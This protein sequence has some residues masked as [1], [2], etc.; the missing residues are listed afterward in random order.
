MTRRIAVPFSDHG[1]STDVRTMADSGRSATSSLSGR[2]EWATTS[3]T[4]PMDITAS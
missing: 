3:S 2:P 4:L 1:H